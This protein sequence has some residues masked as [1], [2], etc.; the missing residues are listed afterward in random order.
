VVFGGT[1]F[2]EYPFLL[3]N[4]ALAICGGTALILAVF[5]LEETEAFLE[6]K[7]DKSRS[8]LTAS[9]PA[10]MVWS[11]NIV[12]VLVA[13]SLFM[14]YT[15]ARL[16]ALVLVMSLPT[17][18]QGMNFSP[19]DWGCIQPG[20]GLALIWTAS[21]LYP[22]V[23][24]RL[25]PRRTFMVGLAS[26][27][28]LTLPFP[29]YCLAWWPAAPLL[30]KYLPIG[31]FQALSSVG[32]GFG[33]PTLD[34]LMNQECDVANRGTVFGLRSSLNAAGG[35]LGGL[36]ASCFVQLG[37]QVEAYVSVGRYLVFYVNIIVGLCTMLAVGQLT[38]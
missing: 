11:R 4:L 22:R 21:W 15:M 27:V 16:Q 2:E 12:L 10:S 18:M 38:Q 35:C 9:K 7:V 36:Y 23:V 1:I 31:L 19:Q 5:S 28:A 26:T 6:A 37:C 29:L 25:G 34:V 32:F 20:Y 14:W 13:H 30:A 8:S 24:D 17:D 3:P 33:F